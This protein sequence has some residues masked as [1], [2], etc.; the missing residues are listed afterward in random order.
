MIRSPV[1]QV[2]PFESLG[3]SSRAFLGGSIEDGLKCRGYRLSR[4]LLHCQPAHQGDGNQSHVPNRMLRAFNYSRYDN[5]QIE[6]LIISYLLR[7]GRRSRLEAAVVVMMTKPAQENASMI[8]FSLVRCT[9]V[10]CLNRDA[11]F[12]DNLPAR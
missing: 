4:A 2:A 12:Q 10:L 7:G 6:K 8:K 11:R 5:Y 9:V 1:F 3:A